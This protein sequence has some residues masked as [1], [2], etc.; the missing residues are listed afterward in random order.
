MAMRKM[1]LIGAADV[2]KTLFGAIG[3]LLDYPGI[4]P[5]IEIV[6]IVGKDGLD[7]YTPIMAKDV[8]WAKLRESNDIFG[9]ALFC[10]TEDDEDGFGEIM[11]PLVFDDL[12]GSIEGTEAE[13]LEEDEPDAYVAIIRAEWGN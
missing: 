11:T 12:E 9:Q 13:M 1:L 5:K 6:P 7:H 2:H 4:K 3:N 10:G 8:D